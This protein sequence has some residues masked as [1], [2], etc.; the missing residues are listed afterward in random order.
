MIRHRGHFAVIRVL[1]DESDHLILAAVRY[2]VDGIHQ[3][4][5]AVLQEGA[6]V[7]DL[8]ADES[9][10]IPFGHA[11]H[12]GAGPGDIGLLIPVVTRQQRCQGAGQPAFSPIVADRIGGRAVPLG[13]QVNLS[14]RACQLSR[15]GFVQLRLEVIGRCAGFVQIPAAK[16]L[17]LQDGR[18]DHLRFSH[19][20]DGLLL[21]LLP[22]VG[23][24][25]H[26]AGHRLPRLVE[27]HVLSRHGFGQGAGLFVRVAFPAVGGRIYLALNI[28]QAGIVWHRMIIPESRVQLR[29]I[30]DSLVH[31]GLRRA[32]HR[33]AVHRAV[34]RLPEGDAVLKREVVKI[35][36]L[37]RIGIAG[38][39]ITIPMS[40]L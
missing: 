13:V 32:G 4:G 6:A 23:M 21:I 33:N 34:F 28:R 40:I 20:M 26:G 12:Q 14:V 36:R 30:I 27:H 11:L 8:P 22:V 38:G 31:D 16:Q 18:R 25:H 7:A 1:R 29:I 19:K 3:E 17:S 15:L 5:H 10:P 24:E 35:D 9:H 39:F 37:R 2:V